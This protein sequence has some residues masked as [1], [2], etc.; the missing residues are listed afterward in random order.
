MMTFSPINNGAHVQ[1]DI[2]LIVQTLFTILIVPT[3]IYEKVLSMI[4]TANNFVFLT[5]N[6]TINID[7]LISAEKTSMNSTKMV[8][9]SVLDQTVNN[10]PNFM[11]K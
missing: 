7:E 10:D 3:D 8:F 9:A 2:K 4:L 11:I 5:Q 1:I 6:I